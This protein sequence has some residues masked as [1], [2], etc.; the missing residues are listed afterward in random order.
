MTMTRPDF[1]VQGRISGFGI[2]PLIF[3]CFPLLP[4]QINCNKIENLRE[5]P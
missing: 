5:I 4:K 1:F 2:R 3:R